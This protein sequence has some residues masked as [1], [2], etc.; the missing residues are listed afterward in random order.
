MFLPLSLQRLPKESL[1]S[2]PIIVKIIDNRPFG[3]RPVVGQCT[4]RSLEDFYCDPY[5]EEMD[6]PQEHSGTCCH[7]DRAGCTPEPFSRRSYGSLY[8]LL[9]AHPSCKV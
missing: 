2:P 7:E 1:Y 4:I 8:A 6:G 9:L 5:R 3:R